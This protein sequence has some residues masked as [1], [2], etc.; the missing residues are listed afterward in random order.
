MSKNRTERFVFR[1][2][3]KPNINKVRMLRQS[4]CNLFSRKTNTFDFVLKF[5]R[6]TQTIFKKGKLKTS[7]QTNDLCNTRKKIRNIIRY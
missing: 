2:K 6:I 1:N 4:C 7:D 5:A 3:G